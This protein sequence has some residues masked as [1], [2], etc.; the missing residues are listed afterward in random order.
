VK[1]ALFSVPAAALVGASSI[2]LPLLA[3]IYFI[4]SLLFSHLSTITIY[5]ILEE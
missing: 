1:T 3:F 4:L 5:Y 2:L